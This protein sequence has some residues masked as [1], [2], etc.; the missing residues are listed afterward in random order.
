M[1]AKLGTTTLLESAA[2]FGILWFSVRI[3]NSEFYP[4]WIPAIINEPLVELLASFVVV[5]ASA[6]V[7]A[8]VDGGTSAATRQVLA[9]TKVAGQENWY[10][11]LKKPSWNPPGWVFPI[12]WLVVSKPTQLCAMSRI[13]KFG[14]KDS[15]EASWMAIGIYTTHLALGDVSN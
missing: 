15:P 2:L 14:L 5:F 13:L 8:I 11:N 1:M 3:A 4:P 12:M 9:V 6:F 10:S 7:G